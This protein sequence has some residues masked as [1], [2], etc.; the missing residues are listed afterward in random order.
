M[1][2][3]YLFKKRNHRIYAINQSFITRDKYIERI[4]GFGPICNFGKPFT[5]DIGATFD[6][7]AD[8]GFSTE[9][10]NE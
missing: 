10:N 5:Y 7:L 3:Q 6:F 9:V 8:V 1:N 4:L 2:K